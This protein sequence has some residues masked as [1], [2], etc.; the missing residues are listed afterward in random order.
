VTNTSPVLE[1]ISVSKSFVGVRALQ[2]VDFTLRPGQVHALVGENGAGKSTLIKVATG[3]YQPD[4]GEIRLDGRPVHFPSPLAAQEAGISTIYQEINLVP[5]MSVARNLYLNREPRRFGLIDAARM[6]RDARRV[7]RQYGVDVNVARPLRELGLGAQQMVAIAR[8]VQI[9]ARVVI[10]DEPTSSLEHREVE[11]LFRMIEQLR[12]QG[13]AI[14]YVSHRLDE[15]FRICDAVTVMRD[16]R[17]VHTGAMRDLDRLHLVSLML[18]RDIAE[19]RRHGT[20]DF[21]S[22]HHIGDRPV[23]RAENLSSRRVLEDVSL[24][25][26]PGE[27]VGLG[28]LLGAGRSET[29]KAVV[30]ALHTE[31]GR[32][33]IDG[34]PVRR[35]STAA[36]IRAG[37]VLLP[38][39]RK[40][41]GI[42]PNLSVRENIVLAALPRISRAGL[43]TR[44]K[45]D[46]IVDYFMKRLRIKASSPDQK[47][48]ELS[49]GNQ[50]KVLLARWLCLNPKVLLLDEPTRGID[51]GAKAEVQGVIDELAKDGLGVVLISS[52]LEELIE[53]SNRVVVLKDGRKVGELTGN[54]VSEDALMQSLAQAPGGTATTDG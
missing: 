18:G 7:L 38:E 26:R 31:S 27:V 16:G 42:V 48:G 22:V 3:V 50:Q 14:L 23:L 40:S 32:V 11:T 30:G 6:R 51:V 33:E 29:A 19:V 43:V 39:D 46:E 37:A 54:D 20:T 35:N 9:D 15:L 53:G 4:A 12:E 21:G 24:E 52:E 8:A 47:V 34:T 25:V 5:L 17:V 10:M 45:Q 36:A 41:E 49:G 1:L 28:G 44:A 13:I 2:D